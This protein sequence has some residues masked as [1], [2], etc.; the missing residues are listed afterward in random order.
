MDKTSDELAYERYMRGEYTYE[1]YLDV[2]AN[3]DSQPLL[4][5][6]FAES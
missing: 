3:E 1:E 2:C 6:N 4:R 5:Q